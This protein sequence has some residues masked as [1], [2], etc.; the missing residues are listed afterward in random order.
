M[1]GLIGRWWQSLV[2]RA[3]NAPDNDAEPHTCV[4]G[5]E[6]LNWLF[7]RHT[8]VNADIARKLLSPGASDSQ[9]PLQSVNRCSAPVV[10][11]ACEKKIRRSLAWCG[12]FVAVISREAATSDWVRFEIEWAAAH[13]DANHAISMV[14][15][16]TPP[17]ALHPWLRLVRQI[18]CSRDRNRDDIDLDLRQVMQRW[19]A[20]L[21]M[22][23]DR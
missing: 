9:I 15:D 5:E 12:R 7:A 16:E 2:Y 23:D 14:L 19:S 22:G 1:R 21:A 17:A 8:T 10:S 3:P 11:E 4:P 18:D 6:H 13:R 20:Q